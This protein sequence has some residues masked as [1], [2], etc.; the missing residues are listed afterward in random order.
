MLKVSLLPESYRKKIVGSKKKEQIKKISL[1]ALIMLFVFFMVVM[2]TRQYVSSKYNSI[3]KVNA[4]AK[5]MFPVL[6]SFQALYNDIQAQRE[7]INVVSAKKP[8]AHDF[9]VALGNIEYPGL[10]L[11]KISADDWFY[12]KKCSVEGKCLSYADLL[13]Y[14]EKV[15]DIED[16]LDVTLGTFSYTDEKTDTD[17][18]ICSFS[19]TV[20]CGG[21]GT[22]FE[23]ST[24]PT[25]ATETETED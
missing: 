23:T 18:R 13:D 7:L 3:N 12:S 20:I 11:T 22:P 21:T 8:Y 17:E 9:V 1:V 5:A 6:E 14:I 15:K 2:S 16:V 24:V 19:I 4:E 25:S 10:W